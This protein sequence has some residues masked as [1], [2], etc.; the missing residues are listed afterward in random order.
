MDRLTEEENRIAD[1]IMNSDDPRDRAKVAYIDLAY[2]IF[3]SIALCVCV[4][5][6]R[7]PALHSVINE[8]YEPVGEFVSDQMDEM[9]T[10]ESL[11]LIFNKIMIRSRAL[12]EDALGVPRFDG[13]SNGS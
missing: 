5:H 13:T 8:V 2:A 6:N 7:L 12:V 1:K 10:K 11:N 3:R 4:S 9:T